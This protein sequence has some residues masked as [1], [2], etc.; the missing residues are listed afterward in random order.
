MLSVQNVTKTFGHHTALSELTLEVASGETVCLLGANG[1]GKTTTINLL[2]GFSA[3]DQGVVRVDGRDPIKESI[4]TRQAL[5]YIP[6][7]VA[8]YPSLSGLE[9]LA[10]FDRLSGHK[11]SSAELKALL[12]D[13]GLQERDITRPVSAYSKGMRQK[14]GLAI[15]FAKKA[16]AL[17]LDEPMSGL[18]PKAASDFTQRLT[19]FNDAGCA[20]LIATHDIFRAKESAS[21]I[22]IMKAGRLVDMIDPTGLDAGR[23]EQIYLQHMH[24]DVAS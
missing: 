14:V 19:T 5:A 12:L 10:Y 6:E 13:V 16:K 1:A 9:N 23:I 15:A 7:N 3:P 8:L 22:G 4:K 11:R 18:D 17:L 20:V 2:L 21:R 24:A